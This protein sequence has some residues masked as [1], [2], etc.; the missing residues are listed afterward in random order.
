MPARSS[1]LFSPVSLPFI[2]EVPL[3]PVSSFSNS[4]SSALQSPPP[5][6][7]RTRQTPVATATST[8]KSTAIAPGPAST[9]ALQRQT[10]TH[11]ACKAA[12]YSGHGTAA[13]GCILLGDDGHPPLA[14]KGS[15]CLSR[16]SAGRDSARF[17]SSKNIKLCLLQASPCARVDC[18]APAPVPALDPHETAMGQNV[19]LLAPSALRKGNTKPAAI[20]FS[21]V[22][23]HGDSDAP[24]SPKKVR[25][26]SVAEGGC[27]AYKLVRQRPPLARNKRRSLFSP[28]NDG[29]SDCEAARRPISVAGTLPTRSHDRDAQAWADGET[30]FFDEIMRSCEALKKHTRQRPSPRRIVSRTSAA[31]LT[32]PTTWTSMSTFMP[33]AVGATPAFGKSAPMRSGN[34]PA[35]YSHRAYSVAATGKRNERDAQSAQFSKVPGTRPQKPYRCRAFAISAKAYSPLTVFRAHLPGGCHTGAPCPPVVDT[36]VVNRNDFHTE[37]WERMMEPPSYFVRAEVNADISSCG[38][39]SMNFRKRAVELGLVGEIWNFVR[40]FEMNRHRSRMVC[41]YAAR[42]PVSN[43]L[44]YDSLWPVGYDGG[45]QN[46][47]TMLDIT[48]LAGSIPSDKQVSLSFMIEDIFS[49]GPEAAARVVAK[50]TTLL[51]EVASLCKAWVARRDTLPKPPHVPE[52]YLPHTTVVGPDELFLEVKRGVYYVIASGKVVKFM[53]KHSSMADFVA[54]VNVGLHIGAVKGM[55]SISWVCPEA[56]CTVMDFA[57]LALQDV[58]NGDLNCELNLRTT[59]EEGRPELVQHHMPPSNMRGLLYG[60]IMLQA[61]GRL[62]SNL[63]SDCRLRILDSF[64]A[65][66]VANIMRNRLLDQLPFALAEMVNIVTRLAQQGLVNPDIKSDNIVLDGLTGQ[67]KMIDFGLVVPAGTQDICRGSVS[68]ERAACLSFPQTAPEYL[69][70]EPC[71]ESAM[72]Y[73]LCYM[74]GSLLEV[75]SRRTGDMAAVSMSVNIPLI[76]F[77]A[78]SYKEDQKLRPRVHEMAPIIA[79]CFPFKPHIARLFCEPKHTIL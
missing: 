66:G 73:G 24:N 74:V 33:S 53:M 43:Y 72:A 23:Q 35:G 75:L 32:T 36:L 62:P 56:F 70:G 78:K 30:Y 52:A 55:S 60:V 65:V 4:P 11:R 3:S 41:K 63:Q 77:F 42:R 17:C 38:N 46:G 57:G 76:N 26:S 22:H 44:M 28:E 16:Y 13:A 10:C 45:S 40:N 12:A 51:R 39:S 8:F 31:A 1:S 27:N 6:V 5:P 25:I 54:E 29:R 37:K 58:I 59:R 61:T 7:R 9:A 79:S 14:S 19:G 48:P 2:S 49:L 64:S 34:Q 21:L 71:N 20:D 15:G 69:K 50:Q 67:P 47:K 18:L 68:S